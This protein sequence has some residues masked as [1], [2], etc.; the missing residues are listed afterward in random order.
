MAQKDQKGLADPE[1]GF[2]LMATITALVITRNSAD[3]IEG[4][5]KGLTWADGV[6]VVD[7]G[8]T[9]ETCELA[10]KYTDT[11][12][13]HEWPGH[14]AQKNFGHTLVG[15]DW[16]LSIDAD[17]RVTEELQ[18]EIRAAVEN[19]AF[20]AYRVPFRDW[21][22]GKFIYYGSWPHQAHIRLYRSGK[23]AWRGTI[24]EGVKVDGPVGQLSSPLLHYSHTTIGRF[25]EKLNKYTDIEAQ[26]MFDRGVRVGLAGALLGA[27]RAFL[28]QYVRL[29]GFRD[30]GHGLI[31]ALL[32][33]FY[34]FATRAKL[35]SMWYMHE[36]PPET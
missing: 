26:E 16:I 17:E 4:C 14:S 32:M 19:P 11:V 22:F 21:M 5:L 35:W 23:A 13:F 6:V 8:S 7:S 24:H 15:S 31:L 12:V 10:R 30:G 27:A 9:D 18:S 28:G 3:V 36:H 2:S 34:Y 25:V 29:Q 33:A 1:T 20:D